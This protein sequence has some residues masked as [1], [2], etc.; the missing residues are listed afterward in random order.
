M[1]LVGEALDVAIEA[2]GKYLVRGG[3]PRHRGRRG[4]KRNNKQCKRER[5]VKARH[6]HRA[7]ACAMSFGDPTARCSV[8]SRLKATSCKRE[9]AELYANAGD[10]DEQPK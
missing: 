3:P 9:A 5:L 2:S 6:R 1:H 7:R 8:F 10:R 4:G